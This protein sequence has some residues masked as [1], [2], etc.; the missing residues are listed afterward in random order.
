MHDVVMF[1]TQPIR[2]VLCHNSSGCTAIVLQGVAPP[3]LSA[4]SKG[5]HVSPFPRYRFL[6]SIGMPTVHV[7]ESLQ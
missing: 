1:L 4:V 3:G 7:S 2:G 6:A 5:L